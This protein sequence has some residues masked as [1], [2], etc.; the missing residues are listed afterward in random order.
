MRALRAAALLLQVLLIALPLSLQPAKR[1]ASSRRLRTR[2]PATALPPARPREA[3]PAC[4]SPTGRISLVVL[5]TQTQDGLQSLSL[6]R[7]TVR[8]SQISANNSQV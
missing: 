6:L 1:H 8:S 3:Q 4:L 5:R 7:H 2:P